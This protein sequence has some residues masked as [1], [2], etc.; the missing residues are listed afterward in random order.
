MAKIN[1]FL[2]GKTYSIEEEVFAN[3]KNAIKT[4]LSNISGPDTF[5]TFDGMQYGL[6]I[7]KLQEL[8]QTF[9]NYLESISGEGESIIIDGVEYNIDSNN[10]SSA[11]IN[12]EEA[13]ND[14][15]DIEID[16]NVVGTW[17]FTGE[18]YTPINKT[19]ANGSE[20]IAVPALVE[21]GGSAWQEI[22]HFEFKDAYTVDIRFNIKSR[23]IGEMSD[24]LYNNGVLVG[25]T[26]T[27]TI[28]EQPEDQDFIDWL[29]VNAVRVE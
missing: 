4:H 9:V 19:F 25:S 1:I 8:K 5:I 13:L 7:L 23:S 15:S 21:L 3:T 27:I 28:T 11:I 16:N 2:N 20:F 14:F 6:D 17:R 22:T 29:K 12:L 26:S 10:L 24:I 18:G